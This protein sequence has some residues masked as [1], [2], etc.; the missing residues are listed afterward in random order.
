MRARSLSQMTTRVIAH[1]RET[2]N[3]IER[4]DSTS[5]QLRTPAVAGVLKCCAVESLLSILLSVAL[6]WATTRV[7]IWL[8]DR[9]RI[10]GRS[11]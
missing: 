10:R 6:A 8:S 3:R 11:A 9:T 7:I 1:A 4:S 5:Q 2:P